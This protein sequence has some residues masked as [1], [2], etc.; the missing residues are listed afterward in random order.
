MNNYLHLNENHQRTFRTGV[1]AANA[2][3]AFGLI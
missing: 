3:N 1:N 2:L